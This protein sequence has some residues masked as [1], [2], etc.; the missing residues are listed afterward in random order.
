M[1]TSYSKRV[2]A[3]WL[4]V[5]ML[6]TGAPMA[7]A[8]EPDT[9]QPVVWAGRPDEGEGGITPLSAQAI[10]SIT[11]KNGDAALSDSKV[12]VTGTAVTTDGSTPVGTLTAVLNDS[13]KGTDVTW[14]VTQPQDAK[15]D[16]VKVVD[17]TITVSA[18]AEA[19]TYT[20]KASGND[21][22]TEGTQSTD[23]KVE[24]QGE[25][26]AA[27]VTVSGGQ[28]ELTI[29]ESDTAKTSAF[30]TEIKNAFDEVITPA[31]SWDVEPKQDGK[32]SIGTDGVV[33]VQAGATEDTVPV[34]A[35]ADGK[36]GE[37][38]LQLKQAADTAHEAK[39]VEL[40][41]PKVTADGSTAA[42]DVKVHAYY[43][44]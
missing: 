40:S 37:A 25:N 4:A 2:L 35:T 5:A 19:G 16:D 18:K 34:E 33:T 21:T 30:T 1:K 26:V 12:I 38:K 17:G 8:L 15:Q 44:E 23:L 27:K 28:S 7:L 39:K 42:P 36:S 41:Q 9:T 10:N 43:D 14:S 22:A 32:V 6:A 20:I 11:L 31:V 29:P 24:R 3:F 13:I